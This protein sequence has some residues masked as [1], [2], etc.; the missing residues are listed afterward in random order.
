[1]SSNDV[2]SSMPEWLSAFSKTRENKMDK[3]PQE[4]IETKNLIN[5][6]VQRIDA[7][8]TALK[9]LRESITTML[10]GRLDKMESGP[11]SL[12]SAYPPSSLP[13][14]RHGVGSRRLSFDGD[15]MGNDTEP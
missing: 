5:K 12:A 14:S 2:P 1:M 11:P 15:N 9:K 7:Q 13:P 3:V 10:R 8:D 6:A 4:Q